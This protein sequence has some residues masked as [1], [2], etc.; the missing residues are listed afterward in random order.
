MLSTNSLA[1]LDFDIEYTWTNV[2]ASVA[3]SIRST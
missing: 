2:L 1:E 3:Y